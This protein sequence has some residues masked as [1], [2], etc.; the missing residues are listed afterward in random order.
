MLFANINEVKATSEPST[1]GLAKPAQAQSKQ[2]EE[3]TEF[4]EDGVPY[5][6][7][8]VRDPIFGIALWK[9]RKVTKVDMSQFQGAELVYSEEYKVW[10][11][12]G[13]EDPKEKAEAGKRK[14]L[15]KKRPSS[16]PNT[17]AKPPMRPTQPDSS[18]PPDPP[19]AHTP[20]TIANDF[21]KPPIS[22]P[23][24]PPPIQVDL[25][26][27][28]DIT[29]VNSLNLPDKA[30]DLISN[31]VKQ[32]EFLRSQIHELVGHVYALKESQISQSTLRSMNAMMQSMQ[33][34]LRDTILSNRRGINQMNMSIPALTESI[35]STIERIEPRN[36][37]V[38][39]RVFVC[40]MLT[41][42]L[43]LF[44]SGDNSHSDLQQDLFALYSDFTQKT[45]L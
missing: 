8:T 43:V 39:T 16:N 45:E 3:E 10:Y 1:T 23:E 5:K 37:N 35:N 25:P 33:N 17:P 27:P 15:P 14:S 26:D 40:G 4:G 22:V 2:E 18:K 30:Q 38:L 6:V 11:K 9:R 24:P 29:D 34:S 32:N 21:I 28:I 31:L 7:E 41:F 19:K 12:K 44:F 36:R 13:L 20:A 42:L